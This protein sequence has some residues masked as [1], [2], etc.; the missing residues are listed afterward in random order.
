MLRQA[1]HGQVQKCVDPHESGGNFIKI[2]REDRDLFRQGAPPGFILLG[3]VT[4]RQEIA[5]P[6]VQGRSAHHEMGCAP[7]TLSILARLQD[8]EGRAFRLLNTGR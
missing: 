2:S 1:I 3:D 6:Q 8:T 4:S 5:I 7:L